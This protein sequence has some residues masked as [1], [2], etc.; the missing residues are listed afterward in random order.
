MEENQEMQPTRRQRHSAKFKQKVVQACMQP[1]MSIASIT[2]HYHLNANLLRRWVAAHEEHN[3]A[4]YTEG[5]SRFITFTTAS[6]ATGWG[7]SCRAGFA[8]AVRPFLCTAHKNR[9][10]SLKPALG[11]HD[12]PL[13][14]DGT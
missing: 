13:A 12:F 11:P 7:E 2:L 6:V 9:T 10:L 3:M 14:N 8:P 4:L 1:G 5:F